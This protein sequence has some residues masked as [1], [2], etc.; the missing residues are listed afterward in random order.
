MP[1]VISTLRQNIHIICM[2]KD[3]PKWLYE[4]NGKK[5]RLKDL[6]SKLKK[7]RGK[8]KIKASVLV[9][10]TDGNKAKIIFVPCDKKRGWLALL[11]VTFRLSTDIFIA[12]EE[13]IRLYGRRWD[14]EVFFKMY[15]QH[16]KLVKEIQIRNYD[17]LIGHTSL[18]MIRYNILSLF[19][20][21][22]IDQRSFGDLFRACNEE[23][24]DITFIDTLKRIMQLA[25]AALH[26]ANN[27]SEKVINYILDLIM[28]KAIAY[29][30]LDNRQTPQLESGLR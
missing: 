29:F 4:Y 8:A 3:H 15:K 9:T 12:D 5:L 25:M 17:G 26:K 16:L 13:I 30:G 11:R 7:K 14:I 19:Q 18:V 20:R 27:L 6:Y 22:S 1:S 24:A 21:E 2:L 10:L 28:G 23:L